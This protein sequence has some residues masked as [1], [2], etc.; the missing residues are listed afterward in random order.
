MQ[1]ELDVVVSEN[2]ENKTRIKL[3]ESLQEFVILTL[4]LIKFIIGL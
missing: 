1:S 3:I 2:D 4:S